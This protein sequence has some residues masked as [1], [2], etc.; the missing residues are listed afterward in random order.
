MYISVLTHRA[1]VTRREE[2]RKTPEPLV[3]VTEVPLGPLL[4]ITCSEEA[5]YLC[6]PAEISDATPVIYRS[7]EATSEESAR[8][9]DYGSISRV[10]LEFRLISD[11]T[12]RS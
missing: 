1:F 11:G 2:R 4:S 5:R 10:I 6:A 7:A 3:A 8:G 12:S 9:D